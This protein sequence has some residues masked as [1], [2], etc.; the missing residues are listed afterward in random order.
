MPEKLNTALHRSSGA[1][2]NWSSSPSPKQRPFRPTG[3]TSEGGVEYLYR[4]HKIIVRDS[5][6]DSVCEVSKS[7]GCDTPSTASRH[8]P[9]PP[10]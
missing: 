2:W 4:R 8:S 5:N 1:R 9:A 6:L 7:D 10:G 3:E